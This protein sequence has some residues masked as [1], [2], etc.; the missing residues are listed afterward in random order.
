M[1]Y[2]L[3]MCTIWIRRVVREEVGVK[4]QTES[5]L[6]TG[7]IGLNIEHVVQISSSLQSLSV[8]VQTVPTCFQGLYFLG[9]K[10]CKNGLRLILALGELN[11]SFFKNAS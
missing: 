5:T 3:K 4:T 10:S 7:L 2:Q 11:H 6:Y 9:N 8:F 1:K